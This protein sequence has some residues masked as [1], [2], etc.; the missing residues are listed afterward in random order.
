M[1][2]SFIELSKLCVVFWAQTPYHVLHVNQMQSKQ[3]PP[4]NAQ[5]SLLNSFYKSRFAA[6]QISS[7]P[8]QIC[9]TLKGDA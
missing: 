4:N 1:A 2:T 5:F 9:I 6:W 7:L 8:N 3:Q